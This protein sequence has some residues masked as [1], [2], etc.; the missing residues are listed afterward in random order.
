[1]QKLG[2]NMTYFEH[3]KAN[4]KVSLKGLVLSM[5]HFTH[6]LIPVKVTSHEYWGVNLTKEKNKEI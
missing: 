6:G 1:M 5:F 3:L 2:G 4:W